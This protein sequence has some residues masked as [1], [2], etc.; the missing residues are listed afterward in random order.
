MSLEEGEISQLRATAHPLRLQM[1]SLLTGADLSAAEVAREL[2]ISQANASYHLRF[3]HAAGL[4]EVA[5]EEHV[6]GGRA[7]KYR[8]RWDAPPQ[9]A[10][11]S[12]SDRQAVVRT[13]A[14]AIPARYAHHENGTPALLTDAE[15]WVA[16][17]TWSRVVELVTEASRLVHEGARAP[18]KDG[19]VRVNLSV[20]AFRL[21]R[22]PEEAR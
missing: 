3:L 20:A 19:T 6:R 1:L 16:P 8:H 14:A 18:R 21:A 4:L 22:D 17:E 9:S 11:G 12:P 13:M 2:G 5:G 10:G 15:L 7:K